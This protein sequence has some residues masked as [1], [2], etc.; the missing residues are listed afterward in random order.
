MNNGQFPCKANPEASLFG[1]GEP[2]TGITA[3]P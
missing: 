1:Y 2:Q 3:K